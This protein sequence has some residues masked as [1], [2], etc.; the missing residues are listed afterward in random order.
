M[1]PVEDTAINVS[2]IG[3]PNVGK[4]TLLNRLVQ[5]DRAIVSNIPG[6]TRDSVDEMV[7][8]DGK[9]YRLIDTAGIRRKRGIEFGTEFFMINR[10]FNAIRRSDVRLS[11]NET[12]REK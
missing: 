8:N 12:C 1:D 9:L 5:S 3:K 10:A 2:I 11:R 4:S 6:T 7:E